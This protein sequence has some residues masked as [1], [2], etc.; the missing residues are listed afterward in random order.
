ARAG[1][2]GTGRRSV[3]P[4]LG[5]PWSRSGGAGPAAP[6]ARGRSRCRPSAGRRPLGKTDTMRLKRLLWPVLRQAQRREAPGPVSSTGG[7]AGSAA[8]PFG[9]IDQAGPASRGWRALM[10]KSLLA[11]LNDAERLLVDQT[12]RAELAALDE[13]AAIALEARIRGA[14]NKYVGQ[15]RRAASAAVAE[16]GGRG[17]ARPGET[18]GGV[19]AGATAGALSRGGRRGAA[20]GR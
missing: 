9:K 19:E 10:N 3:G 13:D 6:S 17:R 7:L 11:V 4:G 14:R 8:Q 20:R 15:Y 2:G 16:H 18:R 12:G 5:R 1:S